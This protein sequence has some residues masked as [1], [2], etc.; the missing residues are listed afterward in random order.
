MVTFESLQT[1]SLWRISVLKSTI[2]AAPETSVLTNGSKKRS[3][4]IWLLKSENWVPYSKGFPERMYLSAQKSP[5]W[6]EI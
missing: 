6:G 4:A 2:F 1:D 3:P 5:D